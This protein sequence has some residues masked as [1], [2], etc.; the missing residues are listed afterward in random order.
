VLLKGDA[1]AALKSDQPFVHK[2]LCPGQ[3]VLLKL[4]FGYALIDQ[5][6]R[7]FFNRGESAGHHAGLQPRF[8]FGCEA[9]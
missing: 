9:D 8:L 3:V 4:A 7:R 6:P 5:L 2:G 1:L